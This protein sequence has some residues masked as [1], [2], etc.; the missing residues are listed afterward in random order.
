MLELADWLAWTPTL[1]ADSLQYALSQWSCPTGHSSPGAVNRYMK[2]DVDF[3]ARRVQDNSM[4]IHHHGS[5]TVLII[6]TMVEGKA[7]HKY[8]YTNF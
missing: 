3:N 1:M 4:L 7:A 6:Y 8:M 5:Y 2:S